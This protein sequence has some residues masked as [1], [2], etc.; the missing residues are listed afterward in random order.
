M[1]N[2]LG[3]FIAYYFGA[4]MTYKFPGYVG[5]FWQD[6]ENLTDGYLREAVW[7]GFAESTKTTNAKM[8]AAWWIATAQKHY[9]N[10]D[11]WDKK[12]AEQSLFDLTLWLQTNTKLRKDFG[13]LYIEERHDREKKQLKRLGEFITTND[14]KV[15]AFSIGISPRGRIYNNYRPDAY[16][17]DDLE[18]NK[19][20]RSSARTKQIIDHVDEVKRGLGPTGCILY[21]GNYISDAGV[22]RHIRDR[23]AADPKGVVRDVPVV[24]RITGEIAWKDKYV[25]TDEEAARINADPSRRH[26]PVISLE[27]KKRFLKEKYEPEMMNDPAATGEL[28]FDRPTIDRLLRNVM[29]EKQDNGGLKVWYAFNPSHRYAIGAD[30]AEGEGGDANASVIIDFSTTPNRVV[31]TYA[32]N[33]I[34]AD[35]FGHELKR[36][37]YLYG[38]C[39]V[40][41]EVNN[42]GFATLAALKNV[43]KHQN[44]YRREEQDK[45]Q[46]VLTKK[47]GWRTTEGNKYSIMSELKTAV[48]NGELIVFD[49]RLLDEM[50]EF[51]NNDMRD[52]QG[53]VTRHFDLL[54]ACALAWAMRSLAKVTEQNTTEYRQPKYEGQS[55]F[56]GSGFGQKGDSEDLFDMF[57][58][59]PFLKT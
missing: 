31:A 41:P 50:R 40:C 3:L 25:H 29:A 52:V 49:K 51:T 17:M 8:L 7:I 18:N 48:E 15:E 44:I 2:S 1:R 56:E 19:T 6:G 38:E 30:T 5:E 28:V 57:D 14:I 20:I 12:I 46:K 34:S 11:S 37:G 35:L 32:S 53:L 24:D 42:T 13:E 43:Y 33:M 47:L 21:C 22:M 39:L 36:Q 45:V 55:A 23:V 26:R 9:I 16:I 4:G 54:K 58:E 10:F 59:D 27:D